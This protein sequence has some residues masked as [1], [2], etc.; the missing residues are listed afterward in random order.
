VHHSLSIEDLM[1]N[2]T[3]AAR[4]WARC[5]PFIEAALARSPGFETIEDVERLVAEGKY[6]FGPGGR[7]AAITEIG[8]YAQKKVLTVV[9]GGGDLAELIDDME[10][11][12][13]AFARAHGCDLIMGTGRKGW[14]RVCE[15]RG[16][17]FGWLVMVKD[18]E[19]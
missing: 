10:P 3:P 12:M 5:R 2:E 1:T 14:E 11:A 18:L 15:R 13:C 4:E 9:H 19:Q 8:Q 6:Q 7:A 17:R 16:Y